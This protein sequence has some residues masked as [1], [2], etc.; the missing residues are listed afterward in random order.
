M[1][2]PITQYVNAWRG[3]FALRD[4]RVSESQL[5]EVKRLLKKALEA[6]RRMAARIELDPMLAYWVELPLRVLLGVYKQLAGQKVDLADDQRILE[7]GPTLFLTMCNF[8]EFDRMQWIA[9]GKAHVATAEIPLEFQTSP[10][11]KQLA[12]KKRYGKGTRYYV[13]KLTEEMEAGTLRALKVNRQSLIFDMRQLKKG[14][15]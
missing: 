8:H 7:L 3:I 4:T 5:T 6:R 12:A 2:D 1:N 10:M 15:N 13:R 11:T 14:T 9:Q